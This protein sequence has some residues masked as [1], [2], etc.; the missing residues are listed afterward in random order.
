MTIKIQFCFSFIYQHIYHSWSSLLFHQ[1]LGEWE[2]IQLKSYWYTKT[3]SLISNI[4]NGLRGKS[5]GASFKLVCDSVFNLVVGMCFLGKTVI[6]TIEPNIHKGAILK[7]QS[8]FWFWKFGSLQIFGRFCTLM[9]GGYKLYL[10]FL[11]RLLFSII[12]AL[13]ILLHEIKGHH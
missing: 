3:F 11:S 1:C 6:L 13:F 9:N 5:L 7:D 4:H 10:N 8:L 2:R 12:A